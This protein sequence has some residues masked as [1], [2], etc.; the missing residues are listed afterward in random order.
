MTY[1]L[2]KILYLIYILAL[3]TIN[4]INAK[5]Y[6]YKTDYFIAKKLFNIK[7]YDK[8]AFVLK[9]IISENNK[10]NKYVKKSKIFTIL[11]QY[12]KNDLE[13]AKYN[14]T[15]IA[16]LLKNS[17]NYD[18]ALYLK[19]IIY[20]N[21]NNNYLQKIFNIKRYQHEQTLQ[22]KSMLAFQKIK[23]HFKYDKKIKKNLKIVKNELELHRLHLGIFYIKKKAYIATI[24]RLDITKKNLK[25]KK[26]HDYHRMFLILKSYN[27]LFLD[28]ISKNILIHLKNYDKIKQ[29]SKLLHH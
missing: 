19:A 2:I 9:K 8:A 20:F 1:M 14:I 15:N 11:I 21:L 12:K 7:E 10:N 26:I 5:N 25:I 16:K 4:P 27:E 22:Y 24:N 6:N 3:L 28:K 17:K 29:S 18:T 23:N 13:N